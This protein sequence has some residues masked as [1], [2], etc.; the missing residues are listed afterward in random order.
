MQFFEIILLLSAVVYLLFNRSIN[1][2]VRRLYL[3][4]I[5]AAVLLV[6]LVVVIVIVVVVSVHYYLVPILVQLNILLFHHL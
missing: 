2:A 4:A 3:I 5:L 6:H 1:P